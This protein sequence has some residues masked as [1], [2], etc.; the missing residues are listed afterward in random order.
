MVME[1]AMKRALKPLAYGLVTVYFVADLVFESV[2]LP[3]S[4]WDGCNFCDP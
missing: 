2:A 3:L 1:L 4:A